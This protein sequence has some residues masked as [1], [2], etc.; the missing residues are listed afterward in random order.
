[1]TSST[2]AAF[3]DAQA[4][5][6]FWWTIALAPP[7]CLALLFGAALLLTQGWLQGLRGGEAMI[8]MA[9]S[10]GLLLGA[11]IG[12][13]NPRSAHASAAIT[14]LLCVLLYW[15][16]RYFWFG[17]SLSLDA[18]GFALCLPS[19]VLGAHALRPGA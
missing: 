19:F 13:L 17:A 14:A 2:A 3:N 11:L 1:M 5:R 18:F 9:V 10:L 6:R 7:I 15:S 12:R 4:A 8:L 16:L